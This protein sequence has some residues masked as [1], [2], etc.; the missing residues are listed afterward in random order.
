MYTLEQPYLLSVIS[1]DLSALCVTS[2]N[3]PQTQS[4][5]KNS[6]IS[7]HSKQFNQTTPKSPAISTVSLCSALF[8]Q[9]IFTGDRQAPAWR[10]HPDAKTYVPASKPAKNT[11]HFK[12]FNQTTA[13]IAAISII[14]IPTIKTPRHFNFP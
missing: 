8:R 5:A 13:K 1:V 4:A 2:S 10:V 6:K 3:H 14:S 7:R 12:H 11:G 9:K